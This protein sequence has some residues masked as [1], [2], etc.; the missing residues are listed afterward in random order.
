MNME[1]RRN[2]PTMNVQDISRAKRALDTETE[3]LTSENK[4]RRDVS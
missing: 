2:D 3:R 4:H 1:A